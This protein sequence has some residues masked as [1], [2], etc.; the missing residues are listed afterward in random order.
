MPIKIDVLMNFEDPAVKPP[1]ELSQEIARLYE[2]F[3][4]NLEDEKIDGA[5][6]A[7]TDL[8]S[9]LE[10]LSRDYGFMMRP[11]ISKEGLDL[12]LYS[13]QDLAC[14]FLEGVEQTPE[15]ALKKTRQAIIYAGCSL[16]L[17]F[18]KILKGVRL[19]KPVAGAIVAGGAAAAAEFKGEEDI[20]PPGGPVIVLQSDFEAIKCCKQI[21]NLYISLMNGLKGKKLSKNQI[22]QFKKELKDY[23]RKLAECGFAITFAINEFKFSMTVIQLPD[24]PNHRKKAF[25]QSINNLDIVLSNLEK[26]KLEHN[27][28][29]QGVLHQYHDV[30]MQDYLLSAIEHLE[31]GNE[32]AKPKKKNAK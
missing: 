6:K 4:Q 17:P 26:N 14:P 9:K 15:I 31:V 30:V 10:V 7:H 5:E 27:P 25:D 24:N 18:V 23:L 12:Y 21:A 16:Y 28:A 29:A 11:K 8:L 32:G 3:A 1:L 2:L 22:K 19:Y 13:L 20:A